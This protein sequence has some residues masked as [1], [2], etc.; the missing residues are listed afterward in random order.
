MR[1][2][3]QSSP[4]ATRYGIAE[5]FLITAEA[6]ERGGSADSAACFARCRRLADFLQSQWLVGHQASVKQRVCSRP[7]RR[8]KA[9]SF[10]RRRARNLRSVVMS[11][12]AGVRR[13]QHVEVRA[14]AA[15][16]IAAANRRIQRW[17]RQS[18]KLHPALPARAPR[19]SSASLVGRHK[20]S[21]F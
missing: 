17:R 13:L 12:T 3:A 19:T 18:K 2:G 6:R 11:G 15:I 16:I 5:L 20:A 1:R 7:Q 10:C 21:G 4:M 14:L 8:F 9:S